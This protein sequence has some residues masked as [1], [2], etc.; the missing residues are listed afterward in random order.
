[1]RVL[2]AVV[3]AALFLLSLAAPL[4]A[5][6]VTLT[7]RDGAVE[8]GGTLLGYDGEFFRVDTIY[9]VLT[10]DGSGVVCSGPGCP[11]LE[12]YIA[13]FNI[14]GSQTLGAT[15]MPA[16]LESF[17][18]WQQLTA[19]RIVTDDSQFT[20]EMTSPATGLVVARIGFRVA[21]TDQGFTDLM[22]GEADMVLSMREVS[23]VEAQNAA[24]AG[25]GDLTAVARSRIV[26]LDALVPVVAR[27]NPRRSVSLDQVSGILSGEISNWEH[28]GGRD[29][30]INL[31]I[32]SA[33]S[34]VGSAL[35]L[36]LSA[37][38]LKP[39]GGM[40][41]HANSADLVDAV[42]SDPFALGITRLSELGNGRPLALSGDCGF[43]FAVRPVALKTEDY[44]LTLPLFLYTPARR[45]PKTARE[46]LG[47]LGTPAAQRVVARTGFVDQRVEEISLQQQGER[48]ANAIARAGEEIQLPE[49]QRMVSELRHARR[50]SITFRFKRG[51]TALDA[52]SRANV[53]QLAVLLESGYFDDEELLFV[54]FSDGEGAASSNKR[55]S[56]RRANA[57]RAAVREE[58]VTLDRS[59]ITLS[60]EA[61]GEAM[62]MA[63]DDTEWGRQVNRRVELWYRPVQ[64]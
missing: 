22:L 50:L 33:E 25:L 44:P 32:P 26:A 16:L 61:F 49:L 23:E 4:R 39:A 6:D 34:G 11:D 48:F 53:R 24:E 35:R 3:Y 43:D 15:L 37:N 30:P 20:Y 12:A 38:A 19:R 64:R 63:C 8:V 21:T 62:P 56:M 36:R 10:L 2:C 59:R 45:L 47:Y 52:Q 18:A 57:V 7:S 17:A 51:S 54:G 40:I 1:M 27:S 29:A 14:S 58:A 46:F 41:L 9:G 5:Q 28:L 55:I 42:A 60:V 13:E 31:H